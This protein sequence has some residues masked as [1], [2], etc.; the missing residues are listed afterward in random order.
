M[1]QKLIIVSPTVLPW[2]PGKS[3]GNLSEAALWRHAQIGFCPVGLFWAVEHELSNWKKREKEKAAIFQS[4]PLLLF[5]FPPSH[6]TPPLRVKG[7]LRAK[8]E[9]PNVS[10]N[11]FWEGGGGGGGGGGEG[12]A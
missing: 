7:E 4:S 12:V 2:N 1:G 5:L 3:E 8:K 6:P 11:Y 9:S 10:T